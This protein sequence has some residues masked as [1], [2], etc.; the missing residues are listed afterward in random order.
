L[1]DK[2]WP[3]QP[4]FTFIEKYLD[5]V[6]PACQEAVKKVYSGQHCRAPLSSAI[7]KLKKLILP[8]LT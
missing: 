8:N 1:V 5:P 2:F 6:N 4:V 3:I 7:Y